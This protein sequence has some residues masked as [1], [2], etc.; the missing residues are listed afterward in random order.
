MAPPSPPRRVDPRSQPQPRPPSSAP[1]YP[2]PCS[3]LRATPSWASCVSGARGGQPLVCAAQRELRRDHHDADA[4]RIAARRRAPQRAV[5]GRRAVRAARRRRRLRDQPPPRMGGGVPRR[6]R[7]GAVRPLHR[8]RRAAPAGRRARRRA[9]ARRGRV[10]P[11]RL[12]GAVVHLRGARRRRD[13]PGPWAPPCGRPDRGLW[14]LGD[15]ARGAPAPAAT[16]GPHFN[17]LV[18]SAAACYPARGGRPLRRRRRR[19]R[20][21]ALRRRPPRRALLEL[22]GTRPTRSRAAASTARSASSR[23]RG[24]TRPP[25]RCSSTRAPATAGCG[26]PTSRAASGSRRRARC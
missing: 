3:T 11:A 5:R 26:A 4:R 20:R 16:A 14:P 19:R 13:E 22:R 17:T 24:S 9:G 2:S 6:Q 8:G 23:A 25:T 18:G 7:H 1:S 12:G 21:P 10:A 15:V